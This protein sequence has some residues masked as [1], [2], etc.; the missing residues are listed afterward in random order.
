M[1]VAALT[2][3]AP[4]NRAPKSTT[5]PSRRSRCSGPPAVRPLPAG[6]PRAWYIEHNRRLKAMRLAVVLLDSGVYGPQQA[7]NRR[8]RSLAVRL[9][10]HR[11]S[12]ATCRM[13]RSFLH[14][15]H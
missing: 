4:K 3:Q 13:V 8:I 9:D 10:I 6:L 1:S 12:A 14:Q 15:D 11:P 5:R 7:T 2:Q